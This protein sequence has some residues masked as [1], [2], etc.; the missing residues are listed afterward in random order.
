[1]K[2]NT[3]IS[4]VFVNYNS[5]DDIA[6]LL[7]SLQECTYTNF[8]VILVDNNSQ[9]EN[10]SDILPS[11][12]FVKLIKSNKNLGFAGGNN[13]GFKEALGDFILCLNP[14]IVVTP[15]FIE[16]LLFA[17]KINPKIGLVSPKIKYFHSPSIIQYAGFSKINLFTMR[18][19]SHGKGKVDSPLYSVTQKTS[20]GHGAA[21]MLSREVFE[22]VGGMNESYF[23]YYEEIDWCQR[24]H[25]Q[26]FEIY[27]VASSVVFH[28]ESTTIKKQSP[29]KIYYQSRN[30]MLYAKLHCKSWQLLIYF[31]YNLLVLM[32][33]SILKYISKPVLLKAYLS[34]LV[35]LLY[36]E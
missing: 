9:L 15:G 17:F 26:G 8:E 36:T 3:L 28:K 13:F 1:M 14:D 29:L 23:L 31:F 5:N 24:I 21:M 4:I 2:H 20:Y 7:D 30:R 34:G 27:Y 10:L 16:P 25:N 32:P 33:K 12:P 19:S 11:Y 35:S 22:K 6:K 18:A